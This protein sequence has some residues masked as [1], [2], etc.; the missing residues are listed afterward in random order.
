MVVWAVL[1]AIECITI[2][3]LIPEMRSNVKGLYWLLKERR[4]EKTQES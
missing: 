4:A 1:A 3:L 2:D